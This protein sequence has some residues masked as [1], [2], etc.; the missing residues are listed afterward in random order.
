[1]DPALRQLLQ[2]VDGDM[3][4]L[5]AP[6]S[7][8]R[9]RGVPLGSP[10][11][12]STSLAISEGGPK[13]SSSLSQPRRALP[14]SSTETNTSSSLTQPTRAVALAS[15]ATSTL[16]PPPR[17]ARGVPFN[18][19]LGASSSIIPGFNSTHVES[20]RT[21][22]APGAA[23]RPHFQL[24]LNEFNG[25]NGTSDPRVGEGGVWNS[26]GPGI[27][28]SHPVA[29]SSSSKSDVFVIDGDGST[30]SIAAPSSSSTAL[31]NSSNGTGYSPAAAAAAAA[32]KPPAMSSKKASIAAPLASNGTS[33]L[34]SSGLAAAAAAS[35]AAVA[36]ASRTGGS[37][38][39]SADHA[40]PVDFLSC[41]IA[42]GS[43][44]SNVA[45]AAAADDFESAGDAAGDSGAKKKGKSLVKKAVRSEVHELEEVC[46]GAAVIV[47]LP[48][49]SEV[50]VCLYDVVLC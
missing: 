27:Q 23:T 12:L 18:W 21:A 42:P 45:A 9:G 24:S 29:F 35:N 46:V 43:G 26:I 41:G 7:M 34:M 20:N 38:I 10:T 25:A 30:R 13:S 28:H 49:F 16:I 32:N 36:A 50:C 33:E 22:S 14:P 48:R 40:A 47:R 31:A 5:D 6:P 44:D 15:T 2:E 11:L 19:G 1:M 8:F 39:A 4:A 37:A 3:F 17:F